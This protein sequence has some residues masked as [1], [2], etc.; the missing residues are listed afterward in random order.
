MRGRGNL[1]TY[2]DA[3]RFL[4][5]ATDYEKERSRYGPREYNLRAMRTILD[6]M[7]NPERAY[8]SIHIAG[9]KGKGSTAIMSERLLRAAGAR[10]GLFVSPHLVSML[11]RIQVDGAPISKGAFVRNLNRVLPAL[12]GL[13]P[14]YFEIMTAAG[15][16]AFRQC[17]V[18]RAV[19]EVGL[20]GRLD[21]TNVLRPMVTVITA[22]D[23]DH[24]EKLGHTLTRI[25]GE[26]AGILKPGVPCVVARQRP[27]AL[28][29]IERTARAVGAPLIRSGREFFVRA[30][31][32]RRLQVG[33]AFARR[34]RTFSMPFLGIHQADN[35]AAAVVAVELAWGALRPETVRRVFSELTLPG[36]FERIGSRVVA[37]AA[38]NPVSMRALAAALAQ[39]GWRRATFVFGCSADKNARAMLAAI[40]PLAERLLLVRAASPRAA[41]PTALAR[42][43]PHGTRTQVMGRVQEGIREAMYG[44]GRVVVTGS[45]YVVGEALPLLKRWEEKSVADRR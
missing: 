18:D 16:E 8:G 32:G 25:A 12:K 22:I 41:D 33:V 31:P 2:L 6:R 17:A 44:S 23:Y 9:T 4:A 20:G 27:T 35:A 38:H 24:M 13:R 42:L 5:S 40:A 29:V 10:T 45:F 37:D 1:R 19:V 39:I 36:R 14:T 43:A 34:E 3:E 7:G 30:R 11:E 21:T 26:K 28:R 15:F